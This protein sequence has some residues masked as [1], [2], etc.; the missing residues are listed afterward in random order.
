MA[1][2]TKF[3][4]KRRGE[5]VEVVAK[6]VLSLKDKPAKTGDKVVAFKSDE[7]EPQFLLADDFYDR[8]APA[9]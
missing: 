7:G 9:E 3:K 1:D 2:P 5:E 6:G 8:Y 4:H